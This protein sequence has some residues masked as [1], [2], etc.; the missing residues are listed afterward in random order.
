MKIAPV[1]TVT[2]LAASVHT[3]LVNYC[4][5]V[6]QSRR[7][8]ICNSS[9]GDPEGAQR[10]CEGLWPGS[11]SKSYYFYRFKK[12]HIWILSFTQLFLIEIYDGECFLKNNILN[13]PNPSFATVDFI[14]FFRIRRFSYITLCIFAQA[15]AL[16]YI[17]FQKTTSLIDLSNAPAFSACYSS[18]VVKSR[19]GSADSTQN[20]YEPRVNSNALIEI[21]NIFLSDFNW[22]DVFYFVE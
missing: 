14:L 4:S 9:A 17:K 6:V 11:L 22:Q 10:A 21:K 16:V 15:S 20:L 13:G 5:D 2:I 7:S 12:Y 19:R 1:R 8:R 18:D 3:W